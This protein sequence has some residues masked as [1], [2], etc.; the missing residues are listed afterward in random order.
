[1]P[2]DG[3]KEFSMR[4]WINKPSYETLPYLYVA[5]GLALLLAS[6]Y[7]NFWYWPTICLVSG[8]VCMVF[9]LIVFLKR[10]DYRR[11]SPAVPK[12]D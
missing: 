4:L 1:V 8:I 3:I 11:D 7:L 5:S 10:R 6:L 9:G 2:I 12:D